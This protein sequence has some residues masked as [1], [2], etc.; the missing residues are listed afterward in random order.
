MGA[1]NFIKYGLMEILI[2]NSF[3]KLNL[4]KKN[5]FENLKI[6]SDFII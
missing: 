2:N 6:K 1:M 3:Y 5:N 4:K